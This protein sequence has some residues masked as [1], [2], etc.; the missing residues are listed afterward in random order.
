MESQ[1]ELEVGIWVVVVEDVAVM[2]EVVASPCH[3]Q[4]ILVEGIILVLQ[5]V[6][7]I[8]LVSQLVEVGW[9]R[10]GAS[11]IVAWWGL[12]PLDMTGILCMRIIWIW[13]WSL[14]P[15]VAMLVAHQ[16]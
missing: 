12:P 15:A 5:L 7:G 2:V 11:K 1:L 4:V 6:E 13:W 16:P 3:I 14:V 10:N 9:N 8:I